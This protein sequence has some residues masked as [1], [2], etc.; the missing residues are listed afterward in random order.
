MSKQ[1]LSNSSKGTINSY[2]Y[3]NIF[4]INNKDDLLQVLYLHKISIY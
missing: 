1:K 3:K 2:I 4:I